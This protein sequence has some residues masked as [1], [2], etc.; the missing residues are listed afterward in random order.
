M[1]MCI[2]GMLYEYRPYLK[3]LRIP[4]FTRLVESAKRTNMSVRRPSKCLT[5][6]T[7]GASNQSWKW[8]SKKREVVVVKETKKA[9]EGR[10]RERSGIPPPFSMSAE[11]LYSIIDAWVK[12]GVLVVVLLTYKHEPT[13]EEKQG[14]LYCRYHRR[15]DHYTIDCY[16]LRNIFHEKVAKGNLVI[17]NGKRVD[18][19]MH[20]LEVAMAFFMGCEDP[21]DRLGVWPVIASHV[22]LYKM[23]K[24]C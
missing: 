10:K 19:K 14:T 8:E 11:E 16:A 23:N 6:Q 7:V 17:K 4:S 21:M 5:S 22:H 2:A 13:E 24:W 3:N 18:Q 9:T 12:D 20:R 15:S 1:D